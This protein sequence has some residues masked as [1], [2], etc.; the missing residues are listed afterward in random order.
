MFFVVG[1]LDE[2][3]DENEDDAKASWVYNS[4]VFYHS[5]S[6]PSFLFCFF[7]RVIPFSLAMPLPVVSR[8]PASVSCP[9]AFSEFG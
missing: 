2:D 6:G 7:L 1:T 4:L 8:I 5:P 9:H 3:E